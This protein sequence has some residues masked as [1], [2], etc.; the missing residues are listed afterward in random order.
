MGPWYSQRLCTW[1]IQPSQAPLQRSNR[2]VLGHRPKQC[3]SLRCHSSTQLSRVFQV[4]S[5]N[6][7]NLWTPATLWY[8]DLS[9]E[10][11]SF[12]DIWTISLQAVNTTVPGMI[13]LWSAHR[14][15][16]T[17]V[18]KLKTDLNSNS[19]DKSP[20]HYTKLPHHR[21]KNPTLPTFPANFLHLSTEGKQH[22][23]S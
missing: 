15:Y 16:V 20:T 1:L 5:A 12:N 13:W 2:R 7:I 18:I 9:A 8:L 3:L 23:F 11:T 10:L 17:R 14:L 19:C 22:F 21:E 6:Y 4:S